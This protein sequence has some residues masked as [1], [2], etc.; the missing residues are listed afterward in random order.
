MAQHPAALAGAASSN[1]L[2]SAAMANNLV[3]YSSLNS[4][5]KGPKMKMN[6]DDLKKFL[7]KE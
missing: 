3:Q 5:N 6:Y 2:Q 4:G 1:Q 7:I